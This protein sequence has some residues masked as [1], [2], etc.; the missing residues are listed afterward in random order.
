VEEI[1]CNGGG[2]RISSLLGGTLSPSARGRRN[3]SKGSGDD[4]KYFGWGQT[5]MD[6]WMVKELGSP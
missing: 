1:V 6:C 2:V 4:N 5:V 3:A